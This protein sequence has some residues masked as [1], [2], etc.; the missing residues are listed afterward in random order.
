MFAGPECGGKFQVCLCL[1]G[2]NV[3]VS[4]RYA[5]IA[6]LECE[7]RFNVCSNYCRPE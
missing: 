5:L 4:F 3:E 6:G 2:L 1:Q 7:N